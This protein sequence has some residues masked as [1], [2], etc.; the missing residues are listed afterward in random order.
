MH[1]GHALTCNSFLFAFRLLPKAKP[2]KVKLKN[3]TPPRE[4]WGH[5]GP[6][7]QCLNST[8]ALKQIELCVAKAA[9]YVEYANFLGQKHIAGPGHVSACLTYV[10]PRVRRDAQTGAK[11]VPGPM[12][13]AAPKMRIS[14]LGSE[15]MVVGLMSQASIELISFRLFN[16]SEAYD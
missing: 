8:Q 14:V 13:N 16:R 12:E 7:G 10:G 6:A 15:T 5:E 4:K 2:K 9:K 3:K 11:M 1:L